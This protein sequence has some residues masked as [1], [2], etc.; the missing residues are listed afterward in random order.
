MKIKKANILHTLLTLDVK[1]SSLHSSNG[2]SRNAADGS[3]AFKWRH[4]EA[5]GFNDLIQILESF[6]V[7]LE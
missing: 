5:P 1:W 3:M 6:Q 7:D 4:D 2:V